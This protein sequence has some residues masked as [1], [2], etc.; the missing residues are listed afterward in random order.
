MGFIGTNAGRVFHGFGPG[1]RYQPTPG[2]PL[3]GKTITPTYGAKLMVTPRV[4]MEEMPDPHLVRL[5]DQLQAEILRRGAPKLQ[6][7][8]NFMAGVTQA[9]AARSFLRWSKGL[10]PHQVGQRNKGQP[11]A[12]S[13]AVG[14]TAWQADEGAAAER[15]MAQRLALTGCYSDSTMTV[16]AY[17]PFN[18][19]VQEAEDTIKQLQTVGWVS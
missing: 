19:L 9:M 2:Y 16:H 17:P 18:P 8:A 13:Q 7:F 14:G 4:L 6:G 12:G 15:L 1:T 3:P 11:Q 10:V 5:R